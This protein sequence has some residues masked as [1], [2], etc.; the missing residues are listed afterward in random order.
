MSNV[1]IG[2]KVLMAFV[3]AA[4]AAGAG[5]EERR[6]AVTPLAGYRD[7]GRFTDNSNGQSLSLDGS[8]SYALA[9][10]MAATEGGE[11]ELFYSRQSSKL[12]TAAP[13][14]MNVEYLHIGGTTP[15]GDNQGVEP[16]AAAGIGITRFSPKPATLK[17]VTRG[18]F[19]L[20][21]GIKV[22]LGEYFALRF[23]LRGYVTWLNG[24]A[25]LF[26]VSSSTAAGC[27]IQG[28][29]ESLFQYEALGGVAFRF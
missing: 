29:A 17:D 5:A 2:S 27:L 10:N 9:L 6:F 24:K 14:D 16:Y 4:A 18:S 12:D 20:A 15:L 25:D 3:L 8:G 26:C 23:E 1:R 11:Y 28:K 13:I 7:G 21:G 19:S 22:P